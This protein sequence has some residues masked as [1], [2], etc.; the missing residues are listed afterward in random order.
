MHEMALCESILQLIAEQART[1]S[2]SRVR[3]VWL[4]I[5]SLAAVE[6]PALRFGFDVVTRG[7]VAEGAAL[8]ITEI[9]GRAWCLPC[10]EAHEIAA[11]GD[12]CPQCG[13]YQLQIITGTQMRV[14]EL[15]VD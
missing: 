8:D 7:S 10:G 14:K 15:E 3:T 13:S 6:V 9:P 5:G 12:A 4:E 11:R 1:Q 2:F